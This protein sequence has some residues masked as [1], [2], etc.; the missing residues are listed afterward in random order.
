[1]IDA[2]FV[3]QFGDKLSVNVAPKFFPIRILCLQKSSH[4][5]FGAAEGAEF[6]AS[7]G[8]D[9]VDFLG[10]GFRSFHLAQR[11]QCDQRFNGL[12]KNVCG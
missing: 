5:S 12:R 9:A 3:A 7:I 1:M 11:C 2:V 10:C 4:L 6:K 8:I